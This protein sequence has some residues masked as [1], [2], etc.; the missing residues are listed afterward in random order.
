MYIGI[1]AGG[2]VL[3]TIIGIIYMRK[4]ALKPSDAF[5]N[6]IKAPEA[7]QDSNATG[8]DYAFKVNGRKPSIEFA[9]DQTSPN[10]VSYVPK[11]AESQVVYGNSGSHGNTVSDVGHVFYGQ[12]S[13]E[14]N[15]NHYANMSNDVKYGNYS[16]DNRVVY[17]KPSGD[18]VVYGKP[19]NEHVVYEKPTDDHVVYG[20]PSNDRVVYEKPTSDHVVYGQPSNDHIVYGKPPSDPNYVT[21]EKQ[22]PEFISY[23][24]SG[25]RRH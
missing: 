5:K 23:G 10:F 19:Y 17:G 6:R 18:H 9:P 20:Q 8:S 12:E 25:N 21:Y 22:Q 3:L 11:V 4:T 16:S 13:Y 14:Q 24:N 1:A 15:Q 2:V 7:R